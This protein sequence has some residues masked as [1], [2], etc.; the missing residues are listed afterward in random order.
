MREALIVVPFDNN[1]YIQGV[2]DN[3]LEGRKTYWR[4]GTN[5][6]DGK[7]AEHS[8]EPGKAWCITDH[9]DYLACLDYCRTGSGAVRADLGPDRWRH[10]HALQSADV[11]P[12][13]VYPGGRN[14]LDHARDQPDIGP[15][16]WLVRPEGH[17]RGQ[18]RDCRG[19][20]H[21]HMHHLCRVH[22][23]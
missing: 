16:D 21:G 7:V 11:Q 9:R 5:E 12:G 15:H 20:A 4:N 17:Q 13:A 23:G 10:K 3:A 6:L 14:V 18:H 22:R 2:G 8:G 1:I 19:Y